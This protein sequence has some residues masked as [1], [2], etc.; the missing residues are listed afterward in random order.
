MKSGRISTTAIVLTL[1]AVPLLFRAEAVAGQLSPPQRRGEMSD[2]L[3]AVFN[4]GVQALRAGRFDAAEAA[5]LEVQK[6]AGPSSPI[7]TNLGTIYQLRGDHERA[8]ATLRQAVRLEPQSAPPRVL[9]GSSLLALGKTSEATTQLE[10]AVKLA[11]KDPLTHLQLAKA[12]SR[13]KNF[14]RAAG[15]FRAARG[16]APADPDLTYRLGNAYLELSVWTLREI[17]RLD[18]KSPRVE[19]TRAENFRTQGRHDLA[20]R[21][22]QFAVQVDPELPDVHLAM[23]EIY[24][25]KGKPQEALEE[26]N[27]ELSIVPGHAKA[28]ELK[29]HLLSGAAQPDE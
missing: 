8:V 23:A 2:E 4:Q 1:L 19:Q 11:P 25:E 17:L 28:L 26:L 22:Y 18:P 16:L 3:I 24:L 12:Y 15:E 9:L 14:L 5:F 10:G 29:K 27:R 21:S 20:L 13:A 6:K 7:C